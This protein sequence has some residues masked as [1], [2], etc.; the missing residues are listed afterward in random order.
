MREE[1]PECC[2]ICKVAFSQVGP[3]AR[4]EGHGRSV[5]VALGKVCFGIWIRTESSL[6]HLAVVWR[7]APVI[8]GA[9]GAV[10]ERE[11]ALPAGTWKPFSEK[12]EVKSHVCHLQHEPLGGLIAERRYLHRETNLQREKRK[13]SCLNVRLKCYPTLC[14]YIWVKSWCLWGHLAFLQ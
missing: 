2:G 4:P 3:A 5:W 12:V 7:K 11:P 1:P 9:S 6:S 10:G 13:P 8:P 14:N